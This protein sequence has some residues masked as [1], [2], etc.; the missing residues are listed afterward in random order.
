V[1][2]AVVWTI[3]TSQNDIIFA[4]GSS[5]MDFLVD[6]VKLFSW[7]WFIGKNLIALAPSTSGRW[8]LFCAG[9]AR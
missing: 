2:H 3:W 5:S 7:K 4:G 1:W 8:N 9:P 6:K